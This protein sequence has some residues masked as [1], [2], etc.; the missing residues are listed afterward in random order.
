MKKV[1]LISVLMHNYGSLLQTYALQRFIKK[2]NYESEILY[3]SENYAKKLIR[4]A[5]LSY[6]IAKFKVVFRNIFFRIIHQQL[7]NKIKLRR[8]IFYKFI[9]ER[10]VLTDRIDGRKELEEKIKNYNIV[11]LGS[12]QVFHPG[13]FLMDYFTLTFVPDKIKKIAFAPSFG[14][15]KIPNYQKKK[16]KF[17]LNRFDNLSVREKSGQKL[18]SDLIG[19]EA[20]IVCDPTLLID[21]ADWEELSGGKRI[22]CENY[23]FCY[24][25]GANRR[26]R[27]FANKFKKETGYI[28]V[29]L[30]HLDEFVKGDLE[31]SD[32][33]FFDVDP[34]NFLNLISNADYV[35][36]DS[37]HATIF[38]IIFKKN[39]FVFNRYSGTTNL[40]TNTRIS[41][42]LES[43]DLADRRLDGTEDITNCINIKIDYSCVV[44]ELKKLRD[45]SQKYLLDA[46]N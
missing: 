36:T 38:S 9:N 40:S 22:V 1:A 5:N 44:S 2:N 24:F 39:F 32:R 35:L 16:T 17:Y 21:N 11:L 8:N 33:A 19:K 37:F 7:Y 10:L 3:Y 28:I 27:E 30:Q 25:L 13:N 15:S 46:L 18:I 26:H 6:F 42:I 29:A 20:P 45:F 4:L 43:F 34:F 12:D 31:F 14:V 41:S 23:I